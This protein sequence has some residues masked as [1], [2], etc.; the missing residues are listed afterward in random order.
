[1]AKGHRYR[2]ATSVFRCFAH[3]GG[4]PVDYLV[5]SNHHT[6][7]ISDHNGDIPVEDSPFGLYFYDMRHLSGFQ[8]RLNSQPLELL[9]SSDEHVYRAVFLLANGASGNEQGLDRQTIAVRR[10]RVAHEAVYERIGVTNY[11]RTPIEC[12]LTVELAVDFA[13]MFVVRGFAGGPRGSIAPVE[14]H[15]DRLRFIYRGADD[16]VRTTDIHL[17]VIPDTVDILGAEAPPPSPGPQG[18]GARRLRQLPTPARAQVHWRL[19]LEPHAT[20]SVDLTITPATDPSDQQNSRAGESFETALEA[21][22]ALYQAWDE[23]AAI[24]TTDNPAF[25]EI[26]RRS[27]HDLRALTV[28]FGDLFLPVAGIPWF[29]VPFGRDSL[30]T[31]FQALWFQPDLARSTLRYLAAHQG[32]QDNPWRDEQPGKILHEMRFGELAN[33]N[34]VPFNPYYGSI[35]A[36]L[37][38]LMLFAATVRWTGDRTLYHDLLPAALRAI[39][40]IDLY[41]DADGDGYIAFEPRSTAGLRIQGWKDSR[42]SVVHPDGTLAEPPLALVEVQ[43]YAYAAKTWMADLFERMGEP[44]R[45]AELRLGAAALKER[46]NADF[47]L[48]DEK[49]YAQAIEVGKGPIREVTSNPGHALLCDLLLPEYAAQVADR[50]TAPDMLSSWGVRTRS[51]ADPNYNPMSYHNGSVWPHD[52]SLILWGLTQSG[53]RDEANEIAGRLV[54]AAA[55][56]RLRRLPELMCGY[57][58]DPE[59]F[60]GPV[61]YPVS[62]RPQAW[63]AGTGLLIA[64]SILGLEVDALDNTLHLA[65]H[66]P[67]WL[68]WIEVQNLRV[69]ERRVHFR[70]TRAGVETIADGGVEV[71]VKS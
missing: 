58:R 36:T 40:W 43:A 50:L 65:P 20:W 41:A 35:D 27:S 2:V 34:S 18:E 49:F 53:F 42:D 70:A 47:W 33:T 1:M 44:D 48:E 14:Y 38:F 21:V 45:A 9:A 17:S 39:D 31:S 22:R 23:A 63:A 6:F 51:A 13:D 29:A 66:L 28:P 8:V 4:A 52:N 71:R 3:S 56:F 16:V 25:N 68:S 46:F 24:V 37:L 59:T 11:N 55:H 7:M 69:G 60:D 10:E 5:V 15:G 62:C 64:R 61:P 67:P 30:I 32:T 57:D 19:T 26:L 12:D 54:A